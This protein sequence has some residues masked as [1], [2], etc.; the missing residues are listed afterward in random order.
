[1]NRYLCAFRLAA[2]RRSSYSYVEG[3]ARTVCFLIK[4]AADGSSIHRSRSVEP[5]SCI[6]YARCALNSV[7]RI[8]HDAWC[9]GGAY[10]ANNYWPTITPPLLLLFLDLP[11]PGRML[12]LASTTN[13]TILACFVNFIKPP[14]NFSGSRVMDHPSTAP[15]LQLHSKPVIARGMPS[16]Y[17]LGDMLGSDG[18]I[19]GNRRRDCIASIQRGPK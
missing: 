9:T 11:Q 19:C 2:L 4:C 8:A 13:K 18:N 1:M 14:K 15:L 6:R 10:W 12:A 17:P 7:I 16:L 5:A 3:I